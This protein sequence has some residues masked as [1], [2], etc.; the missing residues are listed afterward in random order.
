M[1]TYNGTPKAHY[2]SFRFLTHLK[3]YL[4][5]SGNWYFVTKSDNDIV[6]ILYNYEH[7]SKLFAKGIQFYSDPKDRYAA[8]SQKKKAHFHVELQDIPS[9]ECSIREVFINQQYGSSY[10]TWVQMGEP[11]LLD[12]VE[13]ALLLQK[14]YPGQIISKKAIENGSLILET[15]LEPLEVRLIHIK[16]I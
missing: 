5:A 3:N 1:F 13:I 6:M 8:F 14:S 4:I 9:N 2:F 10:D 11:S 12:N 15:D 16:P 7:F